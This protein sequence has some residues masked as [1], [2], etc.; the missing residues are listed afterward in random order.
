VSGGPPR[1]IEIPTFAAAGPTDTDVNSL[2]KLSPAGRWMALVRANRGVGTYIHFETF[3]IEHPLAVVRA[4]T[5][6]R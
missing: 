6:S 4:T 3:L 2:P 5:P 1:P